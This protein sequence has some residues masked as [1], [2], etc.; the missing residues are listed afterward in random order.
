MG[1]VEEGEKV[2]QGD[3]LVPIPLVAPAAIPVVGIL[4]VS[5][6]SEVASNLSFP[7]VLS[8][9]EDEI[10]HSFNVG[11]E[12]SDFSTEIALKSKILDQRRVTKLL[13]KKV[14]VPL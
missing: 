3:L 9:V 2:N 14:Q 10:E 8:G 6:G 5:S 11:G 7:P 12:N 4:V 1:E 13:P